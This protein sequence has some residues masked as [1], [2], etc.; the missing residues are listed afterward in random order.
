MQFVFSFFDHVDQVN[1]GVTGFYG[2]HPFLDGLVLLSRGEVVEPAGVLLA[3]D[4]AVEFEGEMV[5]LGVVVSR[6]AAAPVETAAS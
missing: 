3:P 2:V 5:L 4:Q 1:R 6:V